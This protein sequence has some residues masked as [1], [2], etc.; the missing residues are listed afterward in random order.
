M[1][2]RLYG[3]VLSLSLLAFPLFLAAR[4]S[5]SMNQSSGSSMN[6]NT[7]T[8]TGCLK[9]G[10]EHGGY[11]LTDDTGKTWELTG[12]SLPKHVNHKVTVT[13]TEM[14]RSNSKESKLAS[15]E[16]LRQAETS[17]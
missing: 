3:F 1:A 16:S 10:Q 5:G 17:T 14:Q 13:G 9:Q 6:G 4:Q 11:Y 15:S 12:V 8:A 2:K 7:A